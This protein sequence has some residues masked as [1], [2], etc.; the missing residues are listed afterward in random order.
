[1]SD[2][3]KLR[4]AMMALGDVM[5][6]IAKTLQDQDNLNTV[7]LKSIQELQKTIQDIGELKE[8]LK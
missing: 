5:Q 8:T 4:L 7:F 3:L 2:S 1:M 6:K